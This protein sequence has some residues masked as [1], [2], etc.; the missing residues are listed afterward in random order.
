MLPP[1]SHITAAA[2]VLSVSDSACERD[3]KTTQ[4]KS[5]L[6]GWS[7]FAQLEVCSG[8]GQHL[9]MMR[10]QAECAHHPTLVQVLARVSYDL[11]K[12]SLHPL[13]QSKV[14]PCNFTSRHGDR[15]AEVLAHSH[16]KLL[17]LK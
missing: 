11:P 9:N 7:R 6:A 4:G 2:N 15:P 14:H 3:H 1:R 16:L 12:V 5:R 17:M 8:L 10:G 13:A